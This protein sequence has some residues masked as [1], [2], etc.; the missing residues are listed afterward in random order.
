MTAPARLPAGFEMVRDA[1]SGF[2]V[3]VPSRWVRV[4]VDEA[5]LKK[6]AELSQGKDPKAA[7]VL[8]QG[9]TV[10]GQGGKLFAYSPDDGGRTSVSLLVRPSPGAGV[11]DLATR[12]LQ[13][14][15]DKL[16]A[17]GKVTRQA[18]TLNGTRAVRA[19]FDVPVRNQPG[20]VVSETQYFVVRRDTAYVLSLLGG[21]T[22]LDAIAQSFTV[23]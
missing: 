3:A 2:S 18:V 5:G 21:G 11:D 12:V 16:A 22:E 6:L 14:Y 17:G 23:S 15:R 19:H 4:P 10:V 13:P 1:S 9:A 20:T 8:T 7:A